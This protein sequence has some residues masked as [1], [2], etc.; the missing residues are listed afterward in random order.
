MTLGSP[1]LRTRVA[2][3][4]AAALALASAGA[5]A[6]VPD[7]TGSLE[8]VG[9]PARNR[10]PANS[11]P[12]GVLDLQFHRGKL[13]AGSGE[14]EVNPGPVH[15]YGIDP[16]TLDT[17][18]EYSAGT[19]AIASFRVA[20]WGDLLAPS[21]DPHEGD[22]NQAHVYLRGTNGVWRKHSSIGGK[23]ATGT[24]GVVWNKTHI[25]DMEEFDGRVFAAGYQLHWSTNRCVTFMDTG[26]ITNAYRLFHYRT[27][28]GGDGR[29]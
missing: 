9:N 13:F 18:F 20:S 11:F 29:W 22:P 10:W 1:L 23:V 6:Q 16:V 15:L 19:E 25:W 28:N 17:R 24:W 2:S 27:A 5:P 8:Y 26:S 14:V 3:A 7:L 21:Q 4:L 12:R